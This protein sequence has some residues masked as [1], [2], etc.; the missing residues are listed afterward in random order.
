MNAADDRTAARAQRLRAQRALVEADAAVTRLSEARTRAR[1]LLRRAA[2]QGAEDDGESPSENPEDALRRRMRRIEN[3]MQA[4][5]ARMRL[6]ELDANQARKTFLGERLR[7][8]PFPGSARR[9]DASDPEDR[10]EGEGRD[11]V[12]GERADVGAGRSPPG[13]GR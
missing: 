1:A 10:R 6:A 13:R 8:E 7:D 11:D 4:T 3:R 12:S 5:D 2:G 9:R